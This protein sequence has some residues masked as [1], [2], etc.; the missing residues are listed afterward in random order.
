M[1]LDADLQMAY[2]KELPDSKEY[3]EKVLKQVQDILARGKVAVFT[4]PHRIINTTVVKRVSKFVRN[5]CGDLESD[6]GWVAPWSE[7]YTVT[8]EDPK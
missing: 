6:C 7:E 2:P 5:E 3:E 4:R 1:I 8:E